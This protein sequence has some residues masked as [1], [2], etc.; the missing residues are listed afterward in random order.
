MVKLVNNGREFE[1][2]FGA[3]PEF[4][5]AKD[6]K[7]LSAFGLIPGDKKNPHKV[8]AGAVQVDGMA[9]EF[10]IDPAADSETFNSN[11]DAVM[12]QIMAMV[13]GYEYFAAPVAEFGAEYI[14]GQPDAAK[15]LG[16]E[17]DY[18]A[19]TMDVNPRPNADAPFRTASGH[20]H[21]GWCNDVDALD[22]DHFKACARLTR[23]LDY[24]LGI[25]SLIWDRDAKRRQLYGKAGA[26]RPK[27][28][29]MEYRTLSN[30][31]LNPAAKHLRKYVF[32]QSVKAIEML[33]ED[34]DK[35]Q[36]KVLGMTA[37]DIVDQD[38]WKKSFHAIKNL[39]VL[40]APASFK[41]AV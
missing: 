22:P 13:P 26:F 18:N 21:I 2:T 15:I 11:L 19:Y 7:P 40:P 3:D 10:N 1:F 17:P 27:S 37:Q 14:K 24:T 32:A 28:Y 30:A 25:P 9:L 36:T 41:D 6:G 5:V 8:E 23:M 39:Q 20:I 12:A 29:G 34:P 16:C 35:D 33:F 4:F 31:W 38:D